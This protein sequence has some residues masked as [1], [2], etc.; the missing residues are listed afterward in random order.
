MSSGQI[1]YQVK[2]FLQDGWNDYGRFTNLTEAV[3]AAD[4]AYESVARAVMVLDE[5]GNLH[6]QRDAS[7]PEKAKE[8]AEA[9][10][11]GR[12]SPLAEAG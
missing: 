2:A 10:V 1:E 8:P 4:R 3:K 5:G 9:A 6:Y 11:R 7:M 12:L